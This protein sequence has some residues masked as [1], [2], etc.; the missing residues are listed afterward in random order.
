MHAT[1]PRE[2]HAVEQHEFIDMRSQERM[3]LAVLP[4]FAGG[5][6]STQLRF[7]QHALAMRA[8]DGT[9]P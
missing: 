4:T 2:L 7:E 3:V 1:A 5:I 6:V 8:H 9:H